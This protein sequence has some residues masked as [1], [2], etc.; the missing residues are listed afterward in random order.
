MGTRLNNKVAI[1]TGGGAG[2]GE[3]ICKKFAQE[4]ARVV[5]CGLPDDPVGEVAR[6]IQSNGGAAVAFRGDIS[7]PENARACV[8]LAVDTFGKLDVLINNAGV[9]PAVGFI[10]EY[11]AEALDYLLKNNVQSVFMMTKFAIPHLQK[12]KGCLVSAGSEAG[13]EGDAQNAPYSGTKG[14]VHAFTRAVAAEQAQHGVRANVVCPG[15]IDT[16]WTHPQTSP[17]TTEM[18]KQIVSATPMGRRGT[19]EEIANVYLFLASDEASF[20]TGALY[21]VDGGL[22]IGKGPSGKMADQSMK[23]APKDTLDLRH[24]H[25]G[26]TVA[27]PFSQSDGGDGSAA[28]QEPDYRN[29]RD[30]TH[31]VRNTLL[32]LSLMAV[33]ANAVL[34][35]FGKPSVRREPVNAEGAGQEASLEATVDE[36]TAGYLAPD[37]DAFYSGTEGTF[38][39]ITDTTSPNATESDAGVVSGKEKKDHRNTSASTGQPIRDDR[40]FTDEAATGNND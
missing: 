7:Q 9:F 39:E 37:Q 14:F 1:V 10:D 15:G 33:A 17:M 30:N 21:V 12:S 23:K 4:G 5:V 2:I 19:P 16:A 11:P 8:A 40:G 26:D 35:Y 3:A 25:G 22:T 27:R 13:L 38:P 36:I 18:A 6:E 34:R 31:V 28:Y 24:S 20:V 29:E 32:G